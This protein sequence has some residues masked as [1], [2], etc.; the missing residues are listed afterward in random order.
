V[1]L[2]RLLEQ[3]PRYLP[4]KKKIR[5]EED[6]RPFTASD[7]TPVDLPPSWINIL[8]SPEFVPEPRAAF[9]HL[10]D[11]LQAGDK[12]TIPRMGQVPKEF[13]RHG[14]GQTL[15]VTEQMLGLW[16]DMRGYQKVTY[17]RVL[18]GPMGVGKSYL[19]YFLAARAFAEGW[20][21][22][23]LSDAKVLDTKTE[24]GSTLEV[25]KRF[26]A[27]NKDIL[28]GAEIGMLVRDYNGTD[29]IST[30]AVSVIFREL[31]MSGDRKTLLL[32]DEHGK[33]FD[34]E[35]FVPDKFKSLV[36][37]SS[38]NMWGE[39]N[40]GT[41]LI[42]T[43]TAHAK[44]EMTI[45][46]ESYRS[47]SVVF[48]G[49]L[50]ENVF[51]KLLD[52]HLPLAAPTIQ[53]QVTEITGRVPREL[54]HLSAFLER[55]LGPISLDN[56]Q[57]W[58]KKRANSFLEITTKYYEHCSQLR[59]DKFYKALL[60]TFLGST[61]TAAFDWDFLDLGLIFRSEDLNQGGTLYHILCLPAQVA[62]LELFKS[63][64]L[65]KA[66]RNRIC[67][68]SLEGNQFETAIC[69][70]LIC[71]TKPI[72]LNATDL[73][74]RNPSI[75]TLD[76]SHCDTIQTGKESLGPGHDKVLSRGF[77]G[78]PRFDF[79]LGPMLIQVSVSDF[80]K[81]N[82][83]SADLSKAFDDRDTK[84]TN[85]IERYLN[86]VYG[87]G[88]SATTKD[89]RFNVTQNGV[90]V[91]GFRIVYIRGSPG[92]PAHR[93]WVKKFP[94]VQHITFGELRENLFNNIVS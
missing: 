5:I 80:A 73:N 33:L 10:K 4:Q 70:Q 66:I 92:K 59:K 21:V 24:G 85:Q 94:D 74:G 62:L 29:D 23:Y 15:F 6:W 17:R 41:R 75:V 58:A 38:F 87:P 13:G 84:D 48:V 36:F 64:P 89:N 90:P 91:P 63:L 47:D 54:V 31:L 2:K 26:L 51:S 69:H 9:A 55:L 45:L 50:S 88:H 8:A 27:M 71:I 56:L 28:T 57:R 40:K 61:S 20:L 22:L 65:P 46:P 52:M 18:S 39:L 76:F 16:D 43:E 11:D 32:V 1:T 83:D 81:H 25:V 49:P 79:M 37:L 42:F 34:Q 78:Y 82:K 30:A 12:I 44:Y 14:Q 86:D 7:A 77:E 19:S 35:P 3:D 72:V 67:D 93:E 53:K 68:G 60:H